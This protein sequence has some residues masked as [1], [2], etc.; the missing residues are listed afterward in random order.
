MFVHDHTTVRQSGRDLAKKLGVVPTP[1]ANDQ[2]AKDHE[3]AMAALSAKT[4]ADFDR[5]FLAHEVAY[6]A[7]VIDALKKTFVPAI[8]NGELKAFVLKIAPAF[9]AHMIAA[10][11]LQKKIG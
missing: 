6:H 10:Q 9:E 5:A 1:P 11:N 8:S 7:A 2:A 3:A 4:G